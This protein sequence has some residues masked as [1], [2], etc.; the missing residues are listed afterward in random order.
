MKQGARIDHIGGHV[1]KPTRR[2]CL[3]AGYHTVFAKTGRANDRDESPQS[4]AAKMCDMGFRRRWMTGLSAPAKARELA[5]T[6]RSKILINCVQTEVITLP[7]AIHGRCRGENS[8]FGVTDQKE[9]VNT[10][11]SRS[12][13]P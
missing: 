7:G 3:N 5:K 9:R 6:G 8:A 2:H 4:R 12:R 1:P 13:F 11:V 10:Y